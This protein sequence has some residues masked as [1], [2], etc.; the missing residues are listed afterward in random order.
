MLSISGALFHGIERG[1]PLSI[2]WN[3][4]CVDLVWGLVQP[5]AE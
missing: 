3:S 5:D 4:A 1:R 2:P